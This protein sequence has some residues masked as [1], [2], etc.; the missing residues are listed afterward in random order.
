M[1]ED[2]DSSAAQIMKLKRQYSER[3]NTFVAKHKS[4]RRTYLLK[5][6]WVVLK[7]NIK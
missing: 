7:A 5:L 4:L 1:R 3:Y 2:N 6:A